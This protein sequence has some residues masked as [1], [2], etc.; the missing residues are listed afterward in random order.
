MRQWKKCCQTAQFI[1]SCTLWMLFPFTSSVLRWITLFWTLNRFKL[2][3]SKTSQRSFKHLL[4]IAARPDSACC[5]I[6][7]RV[8]SSGD[9]FGAF[10]LRDGNCYIPAR[11]PQNVF[12]SGFQHYGEIDGS[13]FRLHRLVGRDYL[14]GVRAV[15]G[16]STHRSIR[17]EEMTVGPPEVGYTLEWMNLGKS[18]CH[19]SLEHL[20][21][22]QHSLQSR[23]SHWSRR[24]AVT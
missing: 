1:A 15:S 20:T 8:D 21:S 3:F 19:R 2:A 5:R 11:C 16:Y 17:G 10:S 23:L 9:E 6:S 22:R 4:T 7:L 24:P 12:S 14:S 18:L 13:I